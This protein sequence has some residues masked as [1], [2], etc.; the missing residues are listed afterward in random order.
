M[1]CHLLNFSRRVQV[2]VLLVEA[3]IS[4]VTDFYIYQTVLEIIIIRKIGVASLF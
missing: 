3:N 4:D 2:G 1:A